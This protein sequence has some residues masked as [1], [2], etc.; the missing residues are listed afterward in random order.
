VL[1]HTF[2]AVLAA[3]L[4]AVSATPATAHPHT[5]ERGETLWSIS[6]VNGLMPADVAEANGLAVDAP[7]RAGRTVEIPAA[8]TGANGRL[9][10][11]ELTPIHSPLG[12][13]S[14][15]TEAARAWEEMREASVAELGI[16]LYPSG[17]VAAYRTFDEQASFYAEFR[18]GTG[19]L[20]APPGGSA[21]G[22][23]RAVDLGTPEM[24]G[25]VDDIGARFGW[26]KVEAGPA[27]WFHV[28]YVGR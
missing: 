21:H 15:E 8:A 12:A 25:A 16:D 4:L 9:R 24:R 7:L 3:S 5:V 20:A 26:A 19:P 23:G 1:R 27:E 28:N 13:A 14:L 10:T 6:R 2:V 22:E 18:A 11:W 17:P